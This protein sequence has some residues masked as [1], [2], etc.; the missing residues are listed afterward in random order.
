MQSNH[1][2]VSPNP[3]HDKISLGELVAK[4]SYYWKFIVISIVIALIFAF[5]YLQVATYEYEVTST[6]LINDEDNDGGSTSEISAFEDLGL[7]EGTKTSLDTEMGILKSKS[8]IERVARDLKLNITYYSK[9]NLTFKEVYQNQRP[10]TVNLLA[11]ELMVKHIDTVF[12]IS[13]KSEISYNLYDGNDNLIGEGSFGEKVES[14]FGDFI[15][16]PVSMGNVQLNEKIQIKI[17]SLEEVSIALRK[18][19]EIAPDNINSNLLLLKLQGPVRQKAKDILDSLVVYYNKEAIEFK[20]IIAQNTYEFVN[21]RID[22]ISIE[23]RSLDQG[24]QSYKTRNNLSNLDSEASFNLASN[25][26]IA[27]RVAELNSQ[28]KLIDYVTNYMKS[29]TDDLIPANLGMLNENA[30]QNTVNYNNLILERNRLLTSANK[31]NPVISNLNSQISSL[32]ES[33]D[34][35][36]VNTRSSL[37]ISLAESKLQESNL[38]S[39]LSSNP[40]KEREIRDI[41]RQQEIYETLYLYLLQKREENAISLAVNAANAKIIDKS[42]GSRNPVAPRKV[43]VLLGS[44]LLGFLLPISIITAR[45]V[46]NSK[47]HSIEDLDEFINAPNLGYIPNFN[48]EKDIVVFSSENQNVSE[49]F[50]LLRLNIAHVLENGLKNNFS[51]KHNSLNLESS[52]FETSLMQRMRSATAYTSS[53]EDVKKTP[54]ELGISTSAKTIFISS[55]VRKEGKTFVAINLATAFAL[56]HKKVLLIEADIRNPEICDFL[57]IEKQ[58]GLTNFLTDTTLEFKDLELYNQSLYFD[59]LQAGNVIPDVGDT[60]ANGRF[61]ELLEQS[62][63]YYDYV[64]VDTCPLNIASDTLLLGTPDIFVHI[65]RANILEKKMLE[66]PKRLFDNNRLPTMAILVNGIDYR[67]LGYDNRYNFGGKQIKNSIFFGRSKSS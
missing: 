5:A 20:S 32:R 26:Q 25:A 65:V 56:I 12:F 9:R 1:N 16:T 11:E 22:D 17:S 39:K 49:S 41:Q 21:N 47:I 15:V 38:T 64:I 6:I 57:N 62:K 23:L 58:P 59:I 19:I 61:N 27:D 54:I 46:L 14:N 28:I 30:S 44:L 3:Q 13:A 51:T 40:R 42:F 2:A 33:I 63:E 18:S 29:N 55:T 8:L 52:N 7:F 53:D 36:L 37:R 45:S 48:R 10:F 60:L 43:I 24:V 31:D 34:Q 4:Y 50:R 35:S 66:I 67:K